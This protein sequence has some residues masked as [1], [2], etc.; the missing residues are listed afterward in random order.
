M[1][2][3]EKILSVIRADSEQTIAG[4]RKESEKKCRAILEKGEARVLEIRKL[5]ERKQA[6]QTAKMEKSCKSRVELEKRNAVLKAK[7]NEINKA[8]DAVLDYMK[9]LNDKE[10]FQLLY[11]LAATLGSKEGEIL[12][13]EKDLGRVPEDFEQNM[14]KAGVRARLSSVPNKSITSGFILKNGDIEDNMSFE[15]VVA[16]QREAI[17]DLINRELF[18]ESGGV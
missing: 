7:R 14:A 5:A 13:S 4:I 2:S 16:D 9:N 8:V 6:E 15:A 3:G 18:R 1:S 12:L 11:Q 17:E 10:Y